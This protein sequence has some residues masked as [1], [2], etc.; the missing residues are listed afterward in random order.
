MKMKTGIIITVSETGEIIE[1][2]TS[3]IEDGAT[4]YVRTGNHYEKVANF[5]ER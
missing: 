3:V 2:S 5:L 4:T 1:E